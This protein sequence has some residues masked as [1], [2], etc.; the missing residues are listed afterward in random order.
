MASDPKSPFLIAVDTNFL[1]DLAEGR[2]DSLDV[3]PLI[4]QRA[5]KS[6]MGIL[7]TVAHEIAWMTE[8]SE[9]SAVRKLSLEV[10]EKALPVWHFEFLEMEPVQHGIAE[11]IARRLHRAGLLPYEEVNDA[12]IVA[13]SAI[14]GCQLLMTRDGHLRGMDFPRLAFELQRFDVGV[15]VITTPREVIERFFR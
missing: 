13:E 10:A 11:Q 8:H 6:R 14:L 15:P 7:P 2:E 4:H 5:G 3:I 1:L 9:R 12:L